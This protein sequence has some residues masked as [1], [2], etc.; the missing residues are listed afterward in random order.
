M[1]P[2]LTTIAKTVRGV[3]VRALACCAVSVPIWAAGVGIECF[4]LEYKST[5]AN[6]LIVDSV[7]NVITCA[8]KTTYTDEWYDEHVYCE[9]EVSAYLVS[10]L[11]DTEGYLPDGMLDAFAADGW[12]VTLTASRDLATLA[13]DLNAGEL[14]SHSLV[15]LTDPTDKTIWL[16]ADTSTIVYSTLHEFGHYVDRSLGWASRTEEFQALWAQERDSY[17]TYNDYAA[18]SAAETFANLYG[19]VLLDTKKS[20]AAAPACAAYVAK[21]TGIAV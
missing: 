9:G 20:L 15:G 10:T 19:D 1:P 4:A 8:D 5:Q 21:V 7:A 3:T 18:S 6:A 2:T 13:R 12:H 17:A 14:G 11:K 16:V